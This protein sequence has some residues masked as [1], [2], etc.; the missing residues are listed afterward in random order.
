MKPTPLEKPAPPEGWDQL[1]GVLPGRVREIAKE[2]PEASEFSL[3]LGRPLVVSFGGGRH[4]VHESIIVER[5]HIRA[6]TE[7]LSGLKRDGRAG[8][9]GTAHRISVIT[10]RTGE[11]I[12][13]TIRLARFIP[14]LDEETVEF[15][16]ESQGSIL[17]V[18]APES[19]KTTL[20][21]HLVAVLAKEYGPHLNVVDT[22]CEIG[23][24]GEIPHPALYVARW[25]QV[26]D[27]KEQ[28]TI[29]RRAIANHS[30][31]VL[32]LDEIGYHSDVEEVY[33]ASRRG[34]R[35]VASVHGLDLP[36]VV[37]NPTYRILLGNPDPIRG[38]RYYRPAFR[39]AI[40]VRAKGKLFLIPN[41]AEAID[42]I[43]QGLPPEGMKK[44]PAWKE[45][46]APYT[47]DSLRLSVEGYRDRQKEGDLLQ[48]LP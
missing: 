8:V 28:A 12:G 47:Q 39:M 18:G 16:R 24:L 45:D 48:P 21:R 19:G 27:P 30:P 5:D 42:R 35:V 32:V 7:R 23:G 15:I 37:E 43:L 44:G 13:L 25:H 17:I 14:V 1:L 46:E 20:L 34:I 10:D 3:L 6:V 33:A 26:P 9:D 2:Y 40:E 11:V 38:M 29:I 41:L 31:Q 22:S 36:D 4:L